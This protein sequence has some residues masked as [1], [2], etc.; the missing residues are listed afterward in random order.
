MPDLDAIAAPILRGT[1]YRAIDPAYRGMGRSGFMTHDNTILA[2]RQL[3]DLDGQYLWQ[4]GLQQGLPDRLLGFPVYA[5]QA[6]D[7][8]LATTDVAM[9]FGDL[10]AYKIRQVRQ[11]RF[12]RLDELYRATDKTGFVVMVRCDGKLLT[13][14]TAR[15]KK[16][17]MA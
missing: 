17:V 5:N 8:A 3:K 16:M 4:P 10:S 11:I 1:C 14:G 15:V 6:M 12:Y 2:I 9:V 7:S 13:S